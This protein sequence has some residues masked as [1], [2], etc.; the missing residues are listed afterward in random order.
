MAEQHNYKLVGIGKTIRAA[1]KDLR[2][3]TEN[4]VGK[5]KKGGADTQLNVIRTEYKG[6][7]S[8]KPKTIVEGPS[9]FAME[10]EK[11]WND[12]RNRAS[13]TANLKKYDV[14][15]TLDRYFQLT[16][17]QLAITRSTQPPAGPMD[18]EITSSLEYLAK[19]R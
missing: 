5:L 14:G 4:L 1:V 19:L 15:Y 3:K 6:L 16:E 18:R 11:G 12:V 13:V 10:S 2:S 17:Q 7:Y 9:S 8:Q